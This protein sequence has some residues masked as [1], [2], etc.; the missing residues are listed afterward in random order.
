MMAQT[1]FSAYQAFIALAIAVSSLSPVTPILAEAE[2][3]NPN[4]ILVMCDDL[5]WGDVGFNGN[6][7]IQTPNL[8]A[9]AASGLRFERFYAASAVCSPTRGSALTGR[10][11][12]RLGI[13]TAN[14]GHL[15]K[16]ERTLAEYLQTAGYKTGHFGKW[17]LGTFTRTERDSNRGGKENQSDHFTVPTDH[18]FEEF[19]ST[20]AKVPTWDPMIKPK[21]HPARLWWDP[22]DE[23]TPDNSTDYGTA[24][25]DN[26]GKV[27]EGLRG[28][29]SKIIVD[30]ALP[31]IR[32][33]VNENK[34]FFSVVWF[35]TPHLPVVA[36][37]D[38]LARY[39]EY[40]KYEQHY[41]GCITA[42][43]EQ[44]GR[45]RA[46]LR[47]L[48]VARNT[49][50]WFCSD[51]GPEGQAD[52]APGSAGPF[53]GRKRDLLEGGIRVPAL[54]EW[55]EKIQGGTSSSLPC[56]TSDYLPTILEWV[57]IP[58]SQTPDSPLDGISLA[59]AIDRNSSVRP[60]PMAFHF[61]RQKAL[62]LNRFKLHMS[63]DRASLFDI[64]DDP[65]ESVDLSGEYPLLTSQLR[66]TL[67]SWVIE[68]AAD[69]ENP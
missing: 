4:V 67:E 3:G 63:G 2:T 35:H 13:P 61:G 23:P 36:G 32:K 43:D 33:S 11:P 25:W 60:V 52:N 1:R 69:R 15:E 14:A 65:G 21:D 41:Y 8:D 17:H 7:I 47:E 56:F 9:M 55:P 26:K 37:P 40:P 12:M 66:E 16:S 50:I 62:I 54:L 20:E 24:Y 59:A 18:G 64:Q 10:N 44:I 30:R 29:D 19:F 34:P 42:M 57:G 28:D 38:M 46:T 45:L 48:G 58:R 49:M 31:F 27:T 22:I 39:S 5:G 51:N 68:C 53:R 6:T